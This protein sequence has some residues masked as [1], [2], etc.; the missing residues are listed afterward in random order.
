MLEY[1]LQVLILAIIALCI[2]L[3][4]SKHKELKILFQKDG[5]LVKENL[6]HIAHAI[7]GLSEL[8]DDAD[9]VIKHVSQVPSMGEMMQQMIQGFIIQ[10]MQ[11]IKQHIPNFDEG[12]ITPSE[13]QES[14]GTE[15]VKE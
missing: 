11:P 14:H 10:K 6:N 4:H 5:N 8:L 2:F 3:E 9:E 15:E 13:L 1:T 12:L 7:V